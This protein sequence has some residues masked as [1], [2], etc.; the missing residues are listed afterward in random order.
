MPI[1]KGTAVYIDVVLRWMTGDPEIT[2]AHAYSAAVV[3]AERVRPVL[4]T[5]TQPIALRQSERL[6]DRP[7][8]AHQILAGLLAECWAAED[9]DGS[10]SGAA[11]VDAVRA[12]LTARGYDMTHPS[13]HENRYIWQPEVLRGI[14]LTRPRTAA[15][16]T[17]T[18]ADPGSADRGIPERQ[19]PA[20]EEWMCRR[21]IPGTG[22]K[23]CSLPSGH[24]GGCTP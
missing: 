9:G 18:H 6:A 4:G 16:N 19:D 8:A 23:W 2:T 13:A 7:H 5:G 11:V 10:W 20:P 15:A 24:A 1:P 22:G 3:L 17:I 12:A 14:A 21:R